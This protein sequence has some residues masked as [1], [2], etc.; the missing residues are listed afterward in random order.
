MVEELA[1]LDRN[2]NNISKY[3]RSWSEIFWRIIRKHLW[4]RNKIRIRYQMVCS[5]NW[6]RL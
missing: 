1:Q 6:T 4:I 5:K 2:T 3:R